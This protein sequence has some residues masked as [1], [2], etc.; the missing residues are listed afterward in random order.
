MCR[1][2]G[3]SHA[4]AEQGRSKPHDKVARECL[5]SG[6]QCP[7]DLG[8]Q[9]RAG[10]LDRRGNDHKQ[11]APLTIKSAGPAPVRASVQAF[12]SEWGAV[13]RVAI[14]SRN[15]EVG[16]DAMAGEQ[17]VA[18]RF[19]AAASH[20]RC[21]RGGSRRTSAE[22]RSGIG[23]CGRAGA[24][25]CQA[26][27]RSCRRRGNSVCA[28]ASSDR[29]ALGATPGRLIAEPASSQNKKSRR[30]HLP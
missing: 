28:G 12:C 18:P 29:G 20:L 6:F 15:A 10:G 7:H 3:Q 13:S 9:Q 5:T 21:R 11:A 8:H 14:R 22:R 16:S 30:G 23:G 25:A 19:R 26:P 24:I 4:P 27:V 17:G 2:C 1:T